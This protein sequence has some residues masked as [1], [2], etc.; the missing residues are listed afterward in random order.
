AISTMGARVGEYAGVNNISQDVRPDPTALNWARFG[1]QRDKEAQ[2]RQEVTSNTLSPLQGMELE[3]MIDISDIE[4]ALTKL[5]R[6]TLDPNAPAMAPLLLRS[7]TEEEYDPS[8]L[9]SK[10]SSTI[11]N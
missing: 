4:N 7:G 1:L 6:T 8:S 11:A 10:E 5:R 9:T 2:K 3:P